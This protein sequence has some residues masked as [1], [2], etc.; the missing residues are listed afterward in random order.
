MK[1]IEEGKNILTQERKDSLKKLKMRP[2]MR[3]KQ[4]SEFTADE[5]MADLSPDEADEITYLEE[6]FEISLIPEQE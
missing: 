4:A 5:E 2:M 3:W 6:V 1:Q